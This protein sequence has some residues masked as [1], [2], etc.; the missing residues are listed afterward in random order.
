MQ[1]NRSGGFAPH[2]PVI[3]VDLYYHQVCGQTSDINQHLPALRRAAEACDSVVEFGV[4][5]IVS[6]WAFLASRPANGL[7]SIDIADPPEDLLLEARRCAIEAGVPFDFVRCDTL[8]LPRVECDMLFIDTLHTHK[9]LTAELVRHADG[10]RRYIA[11]HD[12]VSFGYEGEDGSQPGLQAVV[13]ELIGGHLRTDGSWRIV[14]HDE[15][16]NGLTVVE[17]SA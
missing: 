7:V 3:D 5:G 13:E 2:R 4:R 17:R 1:P 8:V 16:N 14:W 15:S 10:V 12:T 9:Q 6:T 11:M